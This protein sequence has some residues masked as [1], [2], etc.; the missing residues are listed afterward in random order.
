VSGACGP[1]NFPWHRGPCWRTALAAVPAD[2]REIGP[3]LGPITAAK[4]TQRDKSSRLSSFPFGCDWPWLGGVAALLLLYLLFGT[5]RL[6]ADASRSRWRDRT[7]LAWG[8]V[9]I[10]LAHNIEEYGIDALGRTYEF[11]ASM[12]RQWAAPSS[13]STVAG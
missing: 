6:Q 10:Y 1:L 3:E 5:T 11:P 8:A 9:C 7:W 2:Q 4:K 13:V 12:D